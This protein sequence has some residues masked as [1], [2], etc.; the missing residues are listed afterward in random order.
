MRDR[1]I[2]RSEVHQASG[3][4]TAVVNDTHAVAIHAPFEKEND[5]NRQWSRSGAR[6]FVATAASAMLI[7]PALPNQPV[8]AKPSTLLVPTN[9]P[10]I[11]S[12]VNAAAPGDTVQVLAGTYTEQ[13]SIGKNL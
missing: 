7:W 9:Y 8:E 4:V 3:P 2:R 12:A 1:M 10:T 6:K 11:Q 5:M 13:V